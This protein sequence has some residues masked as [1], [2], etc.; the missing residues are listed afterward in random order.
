MAIPNL[1]LTETPFGNPYTPSQVNPNERGPHTPAEG[2]GL[3]YFAPLIRSRF[4]E[5]RP[6]ARADTSKRTLKPVGQT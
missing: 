1:T 6:A 3:V 2:Q 5:L 4:Q